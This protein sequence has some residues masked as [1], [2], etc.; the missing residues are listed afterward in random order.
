MR[1]TITSLV[2]SVD[3][4]HHVYFTIT[5]VHTRRDA[6]HKM[7]SNDGR[8]TLGELD[9]ILAIAQGNFERTDT[10]II[11]V[12]NSSSLVQKI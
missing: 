4:K 5:W 7:E 6:R 8:Q 2:V 10:V 11:N 12:K 3:V 1:F 9:Y